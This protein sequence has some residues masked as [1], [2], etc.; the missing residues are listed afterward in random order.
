VVEESDVTELAEARLENPEDEA[1]DDVPP[2]P[3]P[4][5]PAAPVPPLLLPNLVEVD[6]PE[7]FE[8]AE[9]NSWW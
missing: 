5:P 2:P 4:P 8:E 9:E 6:A 3:P 7:E 1:E